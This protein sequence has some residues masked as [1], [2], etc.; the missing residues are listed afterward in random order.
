MATSA[1]RNNLAAREERFPEADDV[2]EMRHPRALRPG[3][4]LCPRTST[5]QSN[6]RASGRGHRGLSDM[7]P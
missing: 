1:C 7:G 6:P 4:V 2:R 5:R 3:D